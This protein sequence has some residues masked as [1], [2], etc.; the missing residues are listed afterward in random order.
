MSAESLLFVSHSSK[1]E[2]ITRKLAQD[3]RAAEIDLWVDF[4]EIKSGDEWLN[5]IQDG[6]ERCTAL[7]VVMTPHARES[8]WVERET[9][10]VREARKPVF[11]AMVDP[12]PLPLQLIDV[13]Y[14]LLTEA[15][16]DENLPQLVG[17]ILK[18]FAGD[19]PAPIPVPDHLSA[20]P[21]ETNFF[22]YLAQMDDGETYELLARD[23]YAWCHKTLDSVAF[24]GKHTPNF[25]GRVVVPHEED[26]DPTTVEERDV[27]V[28]TLHAYLRNP[29]VQI[30]FDQ[31][32][33]YPPYTDPQERLR[34]LDNLNKLLPAEAAFEKSR[35]N[36]RPTIALDDLLGGAD[37]LE[38]LKDLLGTIAQRLRSGQ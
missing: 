30:P 21:N 5:R 27:T 36:R 34:T 7:L 37:R 35:A 20:R 6:I 23:L 14:T 24:G 9:L 12:V 29:A 22:G 32:S 38:E 8:D 3:L 28:V 4:E 16:Y 19:E 25:Q 31:L 33:K 1:D 13:Q 10:Y 15:V 2:I 11:I 18:H 26:G 17:A